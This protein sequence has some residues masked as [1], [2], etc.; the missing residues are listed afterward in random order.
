MA[1]TMT[2]MVDV[3]MRPLIQQLNAGA[4][5]TE[6]KTYMVALLKSEVTDMEEQVRPKLAEIYARTFTDDELHNIIVFYESPTGQVLLAK[7]PMLVRE[8]QAAVAPLVPAMQRD[9]IDKL[10]THVCEIQH[11]TPAQRAQLTTVKM[12]LLAK[13]AAQQSQTPLT[14]PAQ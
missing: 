14:L 6:L 1:R 7:Q 2:F 3:I 9:M 5:S 4:G 8:G 13:L 11:C 10:F 12:N